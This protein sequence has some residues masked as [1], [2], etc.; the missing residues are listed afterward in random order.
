MYNRSRARRVNSV[1]IAFLTGATP[2][3][4]GT[5]VRGKSPHTEAQSLVTKKTKHHAIMWWKPGVSILHGLG[6]VPGRD[7]R[8]DRQTDIITIATT[9]LALRAVARKN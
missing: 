2:R 1:K 4:F 6:S 9:R 7:R 8:T 3:V 5:L